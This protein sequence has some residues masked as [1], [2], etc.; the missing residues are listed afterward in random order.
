MTFE[1]LITEDDASSYKRLDL[2]FKKN[3]P[4]YSREVIKSFFEQGLFIGDQ[5]IKLELK[6]MPPSGTRIHFTPPEI[7]EDKL[8]PLDAPLNIIFEDE[9]LLVINKEA[10]LT[11][12]QGAGNKDNTLVNRLLH[13]CPGIEDVGEK[14]RPGIV[15][16]LDKGTSGILVV[17]KTNVA[18]EGLVSLFK[19][20]NIVRRYEAITVGDKIPREIKLETFFG[21]SPFNRL[22]MT[23]KLEEGKKAITNVKV[24]KYFKGYSH[25]ECE[26]ETGRTHQIRVHLSDELKSPVL[27]DDLYGKKM[28]KS[29][30]ELTKNYK[31]PFLHAKN[32]GFIHPITK[33]KLFF[34][35]HPPEVFQL[36]LRV[37]H[38][39]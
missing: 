26:L 22:K 32:L 9:H 34:E 5:K 21:R 25:V 10:G 28:N 36:V 11:I 7:K 19:S 29:F 17:A 3:L 39:E 13:Y 30:L 1:F 14:D 8:T 24:L 35:T 2:Y 23:S 15:H 16:R 18:Y 37:L 31:Y 12:H 20:H 38:G 27:N 4:Q 6:K 33:E